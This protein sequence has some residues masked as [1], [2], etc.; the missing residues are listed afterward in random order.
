M[1]GWLWETY[2]K[3]TGMIPMLSQGGSSA[4]ENVFSTATLPAGSYSGLGY[5]GSVWAAVCSGSTQAAS[6]SNGTTWTSR[7][8][9]SANGWQGIGNVG[10]TF[11]SVSSAGAQTSTDGVTWTARTMPSSQGYSL[12]Y[13]YGGVTPPGFVAISNGYGA[14]S[15]NGITWTEF[16]W[17][18][19]RSWQYG[20]I[21]YN[22]SMWLYTIDNFS[23]WYYTST[24]GTTWT[25]R[26]FPI[27]SLD[28]DQEGDYFNGPGWTGTHFVVARGYGRDVIRSTDGINWT[29]VSPMQTSRINPINNPQYVP[30]SGTG[31]FAGAHSYAGDAWVT[32]DGSTWRRFG[33]R[34]G[35]SGHARGG[36]DAGLWTQTA[37]SS[38]MFAKITGNKLAYMTMKNPGSR[39]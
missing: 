13:H 30:F 3:M 22:G 5:N 11:C 10:S 2:T 25:E 31:T 19:S 23:Y 36:A 17:P 15:T 37:Y 33:L 9:S 26:K 8:S 38:T 29:E 27:K 24:N 7:S 4:K 39:S 18:N 32:T 34:K 14:Y 16:T 35:G 28:Q 12:R 6:S 20:G 21:S 1:A